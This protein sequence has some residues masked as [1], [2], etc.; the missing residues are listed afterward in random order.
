M[1]FETAV[2][3]V[4]TFE[5]GYSNRRSDAETQYGITRATARAHH[6][7]GKMRHLPLAV[8][9]AIYRDGFWD[10]CR[11]EELPAPLRLPVFDAAVH[12]GVGQSIKWLQAELGV[13]VDGRCGPLTLAVARSHPD[14]VQVARALLQR[15]TNF[16]RS[17][18]KWREYGRGWQ[19]RLDTLQSLL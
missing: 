3:Q 4:L 11:C 10:R 13:A 18:R 6:Y 5:G 19:R 17:L 16:L 14:P 8:A 2:Q 15:R 12:S 7:Y 9:T 1:D